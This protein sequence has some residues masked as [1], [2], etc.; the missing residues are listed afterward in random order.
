MNCLP[1]FASRNF[2]GILARHFLYVEAFDPPVEIEDQKDLDAAELALL[3]D[4]VYIA[5][6]LFL[7]VYLVDRIG[8]V[9][10]LIDAVEF[11][12]QALF[13]H[14]QELISSFL[15]IWKC[16]SSYTPWIQERGV[17]RRGPGH[18]GR[19]PR[20]PR[21][22]YIRAQDQDTGAKETCLIPATAVILL[23]YRS[24]VVK[25]QHDPV[26]IV[27]WS[28][29]YPKRTVRFEVSQTEKQRAS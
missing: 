13:H 18:S 21:L 7:G 22:P 8:H 19:N 28:Y 5:D 14:G 15:S 12:P 20:H 9:N 2:A 17:P 16:R 26:V 6:L 10:R 11:V 1:N 3:V 24:I 29:V 27:A 4:T 25:L 23:S